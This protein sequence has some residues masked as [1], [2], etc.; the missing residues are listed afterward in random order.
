VVLNAAEAREY[1]Q[2]RDEMERHR[3]ASWTWKETLRI[4]SGQSMAQADA[5]TYVAGRWV[6]GVKEL[7]REVDRYHTA[8]EQ[9]GAMHGRPT[10]M[11]YDADTYWRLEDA[12]E[13]WERSEEGRRALEEINRVQVEC[14]EN[15]QSMTTQDPEGKLSWFNCTIEELER[16]ESTQG[17]LTQQLRTLNQR[18][19]DLREME[20]RFAE[21]IGKG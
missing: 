2:L 12:V 17:R 3:A 4:L 10:L 16:I 6:D 15:I 5:H 1:E 9:I 18:A 11:T 7:L 20:R 21:R 19:A 14:I 8:P 13:A